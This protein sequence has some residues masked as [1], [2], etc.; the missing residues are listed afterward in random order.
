M[1]CPFALILLVYSICTHYR[2][3]RAVA[4]AVADANILSILQYT[5]PGGTQLENRLNECHG[6]TVGGD[7]GQIQLLSHLQSVVYTSVSAAGGGVTA[8]QR[9]GVTVL[10]L[11]RR[12]EMIFL[13][14]DF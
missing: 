6:R 4:A 8:G 14:F 7:N 13:I 10:A 12:G 1:A 9:A 11:S 5:R 3:S 2:R